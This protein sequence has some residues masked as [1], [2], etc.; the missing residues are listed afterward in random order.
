M[1]HLKDPTGITGYVNIDFVIYVIECLI[2]TIVILQIVLPG[3][4]LDSIWIHNNNLTKLGI[5]GLLADCQEARISK[6][7]YL[8]LFGKNG[9]REPHVFSMLAVFIIWPT[10]LTL[11][12]DQA[13]LGLN[14]QVCRLFVLLCTCKNVKLLFTLQHN[15]LDLTVLN[16]YFTLNNNSGSNRSALLCSREKFCNFL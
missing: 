2:I 1:P 16:T 8:E 14:F 4:M 3:L 12:V 10:E 5:L 6:P 7:V 11:A 13:R 15:I 9:S